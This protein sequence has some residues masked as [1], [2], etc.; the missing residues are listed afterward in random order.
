MGDSE[1]S[2]MAY[3]KRTLAWW[4]VALLCGCAA[5]S[6][7]L[8]TSSRRRRGLDSLPP[9]RSPKETLSA[10]ETE[11]TPIASEAPSQKPDFELDRHRNGGTQDPLQPEPDR[12]DSSAGQESNEPPSSPVME[13]SEAKKTPTPSNREARSKRVFLELAEF[14]RPEGHGLLDLFSR[15]D[16]GPSPDERRRGLPR[17]TC[18]LEATCRQNDEEWNITVT[19]MSLG[20]LELDL[21]DEP[22]PRLQMSISPQGHHGEVT[23]HIVWTAPVGERFRAGLE[24]DQ[25]IEELSRSW[26]ASTLLDLGSEMFLGRAPRRYV[27]V[28]VEIETILILDNGGAVGV[29]LLDLSLGG[30][31][32]RSSKPLEVP[33]LTLRLGAVECQGSIVSSRPGPQG[34]SWMHHIQFKPLRR[35]DKSK[36]R[37]SIRLLLKAEG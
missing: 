27:R 34:Q 6:A 9:G 23:G 24:F 21:P 18:N 7:Y 1:T 4:G 37:S 28:P 11:N 33:E 26:V 3:E 29:T 15:W 8:W 30:C 13:T 14:F 12:T 32:L 20:G 16:K 25:S 2:V 35:Y 19:N 31:L 36:L 22:W 10:P 17:L 5:L